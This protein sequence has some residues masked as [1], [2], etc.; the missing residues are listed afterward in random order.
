MR[1]RRARGLPTPAFSLELL[2]G[3]G[4]P[5]TPPRA[6]SKAEEGQGTPLTAGGARE[7]PSFKPGVCPAMSWRSLA[8]CSLPTLPQLLQ[9]GEPDVQLIPVL[10]L[11]LTVLEGHKI[12]PN[13]VVFCKNFSTFHEV[14]S[15]PPCSP[16]RC[17]A[18]VRA[19]RP[20]CVPWNR[21]PPS[22]GQRPCLSSRGPGW[23]GQGLQ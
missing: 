14:P 22:P 11:S 20:C 3:L 18:E 15:P 4:E 21:C 13:V 8:A 6:R 5:F 9:A 19:S 12:D 23:P 10:M 2:E 7:N 17:Q 1:Q 16:S